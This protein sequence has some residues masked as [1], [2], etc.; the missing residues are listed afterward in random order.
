MQR[1]VRNKDEVL[2]KT[3]GYGFVNSVTVW[4]RVDEE[5]RY[6]Y[7][8]E[9]EVLFSYPDLKSKK[10]RKCIY[11]FKGYLLSVG[12]PA[13]YIK[14]AERAFQGRDAKFYLAG[15]RYVL[16]EKIFK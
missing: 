2:S 4:S 1:M 7:P 14:R 15:V 11:D 3:F 13:M 16:T 5:A 8:K 12:P 10:C 9:V 6:H